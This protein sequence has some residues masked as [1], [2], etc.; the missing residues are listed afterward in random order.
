MMSKDEHLIEGE[1]RRRKSI[2]DIPIPEGRR[3]AGDSAVPTSSGI[4]RPHIEDMPHGHDTKDFVAHDVRIQKHVTS[5]GVEK[6]A[7]RVDLHNSKLERTSHPEAEVFEEEFDETPHERRTPARR[8]RSTHIKPWMVITPVVAVALFLLVFVSFTGAQVTVFPK[9]ISS[10]VDV[11][12]RGSQGNVPVSDD[13]TY[14]FVFSV[15]EISTESSRAVPATGEEEVIQKASGNITIYN[16]YSEEDQRLVKETR[17]RS[18]AGL[19]YRIPE[20]VLVPGLTRDA[21]GNVTP[22]SV[23]AEV[24]ADEAGENYN[25]GGA[26]FNVPGF[27]GL[28]Q[29]EGFYAISEAPMTGGF[30][31]VRKIV[32]EADRSAAER[33]LRDE[34]RQSLQSEAQSSSNNDT[35][36]FTDESLTTY[37]MLNEEMRGDRVVIAMRGS[38]QGVIVNHEKI[39]QAVAQNALSSFDESRDVVRI[40]NISDMEI[41]VVPGNDAAALS[42]VRLTARGNAHFVWVIDTEVVKDALRGISRNDISNIVTSLTGV[43]RIESKIRPFWKKTFPNNTD[44]IDVIVDRE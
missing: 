23:V 27:E 25:I 7:N 33:E 30:N 28:P 31:G 18:P 19:I 12:L 4:I 3:R 26:R 32:S 37:Q 16:E 5:E 40:E 15:T 14:D 13:E 34:I 11:E 2:R 36:V 22:G 44:D 29:Y 39:A 42:T 43:S 35:L 1:P 17:F 21:S 9:T 8:R 24:F 41:R 10:S 38:T 6:V 20:S